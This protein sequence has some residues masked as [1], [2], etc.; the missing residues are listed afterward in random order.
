[1]ALWKSADDAPG[2]LLGA[3]EGALAE[4][5]RA[6]RSR[7]RVADPA[8]TALRL[9]GKDYAA[10]P[11][12]EPSAPLSVLQRLIGGLSLGAI[13]WVLANYAGITSTER[14]A[15]EAHRLINLWR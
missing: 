10:V 2:A 13:V 12:A 6:G 8:D 9:T 11:G 5:K 14:L 7:W 15:E 3:A 4:A 1:M